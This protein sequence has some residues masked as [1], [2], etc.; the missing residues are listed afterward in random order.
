MSRDQGR[1]RCQ[2]CSEPGSAQVLFMLRV[3]DNVLLTLLLLEQK[4]LTGEMFIL[5]HSSECPSW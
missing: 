1:K 5:A 4:Q 2:N 3:V